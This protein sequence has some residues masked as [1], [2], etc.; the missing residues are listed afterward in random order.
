[1][2]EPSFLIEKLL[3]SVNKFFSKEDIYIVVGY[4]GQDVIDKLENK[5]NFRA[6]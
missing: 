6:L 4:K 2:C 3:S 5:Y 1:M